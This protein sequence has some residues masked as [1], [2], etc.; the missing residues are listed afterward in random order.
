MIRR[1]AFAALLAV[2]LGT[3]VQLHAQS[4][5]TVTSSRQVTDE[6][7]LR[8]RVSYWSRSTQ[9]PPRRSGLALSN[10]FPF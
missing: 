4:W 7:H 10:P 5:K 3:P 8:V 2:A 9:A 6:D 1:A